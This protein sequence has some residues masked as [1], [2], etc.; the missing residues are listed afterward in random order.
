MGLSNVSSSNSLPLDVF[1]IIISIAAEAGGLNTLKALCTVRSDL[2][3]ICQRHLFSTIALGDSPHRLKALVKVLERNARLALYVKTLEL[4]VY[5]ELVD[6][7]Q[8]LWVLKR[9]PNIE[10]L[11]FSM[12]TVDWRE[13]G[14]LLQLALKTISQSPKLSQLKFETISSMDMA[15]ELLVL[16]PNLRHL[17][18]HYG[19]QNGRASMLSG[20]Y[21]KVPRP[22]ILDVDEN[23]MGT[24]QGLLDVKLSNNCHAID[25]SQLRKIDMNIE[26][27]YVEYEYR[28]LTALK[29]FSRLLCL[30]ELKIAVYRAFTL[31]VL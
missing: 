13:C 16:P 26:A 25:F 4:F 17:V 10:S 14:D 24:L 11:T 18:L 7:F 1:E 15:L 21:S 27:E 23:G 20:E 22:E 9:L 30:E 3:N 29:L 2:L 31:I 28:S 5:W 19:P 6:E 8:L 12:G